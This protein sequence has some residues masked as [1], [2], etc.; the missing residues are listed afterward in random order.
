[1][2]P[3]I[4]TDAAALPIALEPLPAEQ[5]LE[6]AP[7]TGFAELSGAIG[8]WEHTPGTSTD[9]EADEVFVVLSGSATVSFDDPSLEQ[10]E[11]RAGSVARLTAGMR[12]VW[13]V[14]ETLRKV[15]IAG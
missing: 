2:N 4:V 12:T 3:G 5:V 14:R 1:M 6:G 15:Y 11:L 7:R 13:T 10:I 8:V 9:V